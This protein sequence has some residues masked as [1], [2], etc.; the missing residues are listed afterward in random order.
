MKMLIADDDPLQRKLLHASL[1]RAGYEVVETPDGAVAWEVLQREPISL[2]IT[3]WMMPTLSGPDLIRRIRDANFPTYTY[4]ILV[5]AKDRKEDV[6]DG[7]NAGADDYLTKPFDPNEMRARIKI[8]ERILS[9]EARLRDS[10]E[11]LH[12]MA[13]FDS[14]TGL[15]N[16]RAVYERAQSELD[17]AYRETRSISIVMLD[18]DHFKD[19]NDK[20]GHLIG[21]QAL[22]MVAGTISQNKRSYDWA[23]RWGGEEFLLVLP[24]TGLHEAGE[25]AERMRHSVAALRFALPT[26]DYLKLRVSLG[27]SSVDSNYAMPTLGQLLQQADDALYGAKHMGRNRVCLYPM[28]VPEE[29]ALEQGQVGRKPA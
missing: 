6:V 2:V 3:D 8:G 17:R 27:V 7:L 25:I 18:I 11:Q 12:V 14:L 1:N 23:G 9:L 28:L 22:R 21:D 16:R 26:G 19:V 15:L 24:E 13:T 10:L 29:K 20:H 4:I 5:T